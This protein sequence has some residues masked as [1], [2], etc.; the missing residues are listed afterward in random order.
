MHGFVKTP[1]EESLAY[2]KPSIDANSIFILL[3][4]MNLRPLGTKP[5]IEKMLFKCL[6]NE[7]PWLR[8]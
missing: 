7:N 5:S 6:L 4:N 1:L 3:F 8:Y 2:S